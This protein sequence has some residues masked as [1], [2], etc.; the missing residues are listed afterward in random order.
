MYFS[1]KFG[2]EKSLIEKY[3]AINIS[4]V[5][6]LPLFID[7]MLIFN[8]KKKEYKKLHDYLI[9]FF[10]FLTDK[11][12]SEVKIDDIMAYFMGNTTQSCNDYS[13]IFC[14]LFLLYHFLYLP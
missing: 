8:S 3:G 14:I 1:E 4:L 7:P 5:C 9:K 13:G 11:S 12:E 6:D 2:V 10:A